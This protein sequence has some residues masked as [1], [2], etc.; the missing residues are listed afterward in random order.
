MPEGTAL[1]AETMEALVAGAQ[2]T[3]ALTRPLL[4]HGSIRDDLFHFLSFPPYR[5]IFDGVRDEVM[6]D[7]EKVRLAAPALQV[8]DYF[9]VNDY[10]TYRHFLTVFALATLLA[11]DLVPDAGERAALET[12]G[13]THD[14]GKICVPLR[15][16]RKT[17]PLMRSERAALE[18]HSAAGYVLLGYYLGDCGGLAPRVALDHHERRDGSGYPRGM[19]QRDVLVEIIAACDVYDALISPRPYRMASYDN[20]TALEEI[21][22]MA[23][24][25][26]LGWDVVRAL[27]AHNRR[28]RLHYTES[29]V[30][31]E[32]RGT[33]PPLNFHGMVVED[34]E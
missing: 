33:P 9:Q 25:N 19:S 12:S 34:G 4:D 22:A 32:K 6:R 7:M 10:Y 23:E 29:E 2:A 13:P 26:R 11:R 27:V 8:L 15:V 17:S 28:R 14:I 31:V 24:G 20:R 3:N 18:S 30:S 1:S 5:V 16:L 21:T